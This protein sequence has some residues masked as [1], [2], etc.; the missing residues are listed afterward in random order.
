MSDPLAAST[1]S[2]PQESSGS[3]TQGFSIVRVF[4]ALLAAGAVGAVAYFFLLRENGPP[5]LVE[6]K[7]KVFYKGEPLTGGGIFTQPSDPN[8][9][10][11]VAALEAD[12]SFT[13]MTNG[14]PGVYVGTHKLAVSV[15]SGGSPPT[16]L[17]PAV[18]TEI[19]STPLTIEVTTDP[20]ANSA[21]LTVLET[22]GK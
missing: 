11:G 5:Q 1:S 17:I 4:V 18:Y 15:M 6:F 10:G 21:E 7:G 12:G 13:L 22:P 14:V 3:H 8:L 9:V 16:P 19:R 20:S 2:T